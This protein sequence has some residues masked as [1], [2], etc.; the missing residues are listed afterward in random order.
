MNVARILIVENSHFFMQVVSEFFKT[1]G[2]DFL[3]ASK[4]LWLE[5]GKKEKV[6]FEFTLPD[7]IEAKEYHVMCRADDKEV[8][9]SFDVE[10]IDIVLAVDA[11]S[12]M[13]AMDFELKGR[14]VDRLEA[15]KNVVLD[16]IRERVND[17]IGMIA[18]SGFAYTVCPLT[19]DYDW[20]IENL[21][22]VE[23]GDIEDG[24][25]I[26]SAI[27]SSLNRLKE[28]QA[29][30]KII[31]LLTDGVNNAGKIQPLTAAEAA[32]ALGI[33]IYTIAAGTD[34]YV[35]YPV[36]AIGGRTVYRNVAIEVDEEI[37]KE[38]ARLTGGKYFRAAD[39]ESLKEI[40]DEIDALEKTRVEFTGLREYKE[41][42]PLFLWPALAL[43][44]TEIILGN[45]IL[46]KLP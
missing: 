42:F 37:L 20:L 45:T 19:L 28:T 18:F 36:P 17:K 22:R 9:A 44:I 41:L 29:K 43:L 8:I 33:K 4:S 16:F 6:D 32:K 38:I 1:S 26:G 13:R 34:G 46:R 40:Y 2:Y 23:I 30:S 7:D 11:S 14:R 10:G 5:A 27:S 24:T 12:S 35:P 21:K 31:V 39:T 15:V 3:A 25:A